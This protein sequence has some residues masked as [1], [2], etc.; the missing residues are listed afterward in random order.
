[1][2]RINCMEYNEY[3]TMRKIQCIGYNAYNMMHIMQ[4]IEYDAQ[5]IM[6]RVKCIEH[7]A[8]TIMQWRKKTWLSGVQSQDF[9]N[10]RFLTY[11]L[12]GL[13]ICFSFPSLKMLLLSAMMVWQSLAIRIL[14]Q[15][16]ILWYF[17]WIQFWDAEQ[18]EII[19]GY[20]ST[21]K[22]MLVFMYTIGEGGG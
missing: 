17:I 1:M 13:R 2:H 14:F 16:S 9:S 11:L 20:N 21:M 10:F 22:T 12:S 6:H 5:N 19:T 15:H 8:Q 7:N 18:T 4:C 3:Y